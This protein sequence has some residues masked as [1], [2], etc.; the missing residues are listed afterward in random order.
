[1]GKA[2]SGHNTIPNV[3]GAFVLRSAMLITFPVLQALT[4]SDSNVVWEKTDGSEA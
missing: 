1:M 4:V 3:T 2:V